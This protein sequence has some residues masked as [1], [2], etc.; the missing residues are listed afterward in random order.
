MDGTAF[1]LFLSSNLHFISLIIFG[2]DPAEF[3]I[4]V[5]TLDDALELGE[6]RS[7]Y[8][9]LGPAAADHTQQILAAELIVVHLLLKGRPEVRLLTGLDQLVYF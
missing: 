6:L 2:C 3:Y 8:G 4:L 5:N 7:L 9:I 1:Q